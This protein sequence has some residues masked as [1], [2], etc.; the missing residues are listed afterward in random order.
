MESTV[1]AGQMGME[2]SGKPFWPVATVVFD[3]QCESPHTD[4]QRQ[5]PQGHVSYRDY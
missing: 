3:M 4:P 2:P 1:C 5:R